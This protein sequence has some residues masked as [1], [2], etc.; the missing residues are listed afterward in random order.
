MLDAY[1]T[2]TGW[3]FEHALQPAMYAL[4]LM[5]WAEDA[6][7][8]LDFALLGAATILLSWLICRP[9]EAWRPVEPVAD[10]RAVRTDILY[11]ALSRLGVLPLVAFVLFA[12]LAA[13]WEGTVADSGFVP[14]TLETLVPALR[15]QPL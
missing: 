4:G 8:W 13:W 15:D 10:R 1:D 5:D 6:F 7:E 11:T 14:P 2:L 12:S 9:L 3:L